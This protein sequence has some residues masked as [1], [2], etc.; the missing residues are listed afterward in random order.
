MVL[1]TPQDEA[2]LAGP[3]RPIVLLPRRQD[4]DVAESVA[5][6]L[7]ALGVMLP[8]TPL[9]HLLL[10]NDL[11]PLV[12]TSGNVADEPLTRDNQ[13]AIAHLGAI[14]DA[15]LLH[16]RRI[17]RSLDDSV[18]LGGTPAATGQPSRPL[19]LRRG[20]GYAPMPVMLGES[21][22][23][24][25]LA[26]GAELKS[27][28]CLYRAGRAVLS[29][30]IGDLKDGRVF[31]H[32]LGVIND[33]ERLLEFEP[34][35]LAADAHPQYLSSDYAR[36]RSSG[37][38]AGRAALP[39]V[40]VQH[41][42]AHI[43]SCMADNGCTD[44]VIGIAADGV[45]YGDDGAVWGCEILRCSLWEYRRLGHLRYFRLPGSDAAAQETY[46]SAVGVLAEALGPRLVSPH[47]ISLLGQDA[48][49]IKRVFEQLVSGVNCPLSSSLG[50][51][52]DA[53]SALCGLAR[54]NRFEGQAPMLLEAAAAEG[55]E[56]AY[57]FELTGQGPFEID[58]RMM[59]E[60]LL[61]DL[62]RVPAA[63][64]SAKFH[65]TVAAFLAEGARRAGRDTGLRT[66]ALSGGCM[67]NRY[68]AGRLERLLSQ[69]GFT[70]LTH[71]QI[72]CN[73]GGIA[74]G[75][76]VIAARRLAPRHGLMSRSQEQ[77]K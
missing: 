73:D 70:V 19:V 71:R 65:N 29:E 67:V 62:E 16:N 31:R 57:P 14:A 66:V 33:L 75:Q 74:L 15:L 35:V 27:S 41:H 64:V 38:L 49:T 43:V 1:T 11:P 3:Q 68:L 54:A 12:M 48:A 55:V 56:E 76:A 23:P 44:D 7:K 18:V 28:V 26:V 34:Q 36:R 42:H 45:G 46:R 59:I 52:F 6:G 58:Y 22:T 37:Q 21:D 53:V 9:H 50:R 17:Q 47:T 24:A 32:F 13:D 40:T 4:A 20:R 2:L 61:A 30:H 5:P 69:D 51:L 60:A 72:P 63:V 25:V 77:G 39:L 8:Y 10:A